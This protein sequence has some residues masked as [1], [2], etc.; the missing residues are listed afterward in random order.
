M[1][2][3]LVDLLVR[4]ALV[5][6]IGSLAAV[7]ARRQAAALRALVWSAA[8]AALLALP[9]VAWLA[10]SIDVPVWSP[11]GNLPSVEPRPAMPVKEQRPPIT[12]PATAP[13][14]GLA[15]ASSAHA[16]PYVATPSMAVPSS[17][18]VAALAVGLWLAGVSVLGARIVFGLLAT[19]R[20]RAGAICLS[21]T[22][23]ADELRQVAQR[24]G[25]SAPPAL[26]ASEELDIPVAAQFIRPTIMVPVEFA[27]WP[28]QRRAAVLLH[29]A[30]HL[31]RY[32]CWVQLAA[33]VAVAIHW[34]NPLAWLALSRLWVERERACDDVVLRSG[35]R[36]SD[37]A[38]HLLAVAA[39]SRSLSA[40]AAAAFARRQQ[41]PGRVRA[42]LNPSTGRQSPTRRTLVSVTALSLVF[43][44]PVAIAQPVAAS[45]AVPHGGEKSSAA[46][47]ASASSAGAAQQD[48][49]AIEDLIRMR[50]H[51]VT[52]E[53]IDAMSELADDLD[54]DTLV[55]LRIHGVSPDYARGM[56]AAFGENLDLQD[57]VQGRIHG[58]TTEFAAGMSAQ[59]REDVAFETLTQMRIHGVSLGFLEE[60]QELLPYEEIE[61]DDLVQM[62]IHGVSS[63]MVRELKEQGYDDL[64]IE[65]LVRIK[66]HGFDRFLRRR[67]GGQR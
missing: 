17:G 62:R 2:M 55:Q 35:L 63:T 59:L 22:E 44:V 1:T 16:G 58:V 66:I 12:L 20:L 19:L 51:G 56:R 7:C 38:T 64:T 23:A 34:V 8:L 31:Q 24:L 61:S 37:Y 21:G 27:R 26:L 28:Q 33:R 52:P 60:I 29:E 10:P 67:S 25:M 4:G 5:C 40:H 41:L 14:G 65:E 30:A 53:F 46:T 15:L 57:L 49:P 50:I 39:S 11:S 13:T 54:I 47:T 42:I 18:G 9:L 48:L 3:W 45:S 36:P 6:V 43:L 32:D